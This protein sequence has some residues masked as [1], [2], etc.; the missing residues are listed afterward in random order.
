[1]ARSPQEEG[2]TLIELLV[3]VIIIGILAA[4]AIPAFLNQRER[5]WQ[6]EL[7]SAVRNAALDIEAETTASD[8]GDYPAGR[9]RRRDGQIATNWVLTSTSTRWRRDHS[10]LPI[11]HVCHGGLHEDGLPQW[12]VWKHRGFTSAWSTLHQ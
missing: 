7:T 10:A 8:R 3:V 4:I 6:S 5:A 11:G 1:V 12:L 9:R 2:F